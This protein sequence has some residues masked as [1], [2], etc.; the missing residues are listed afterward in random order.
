METYLLQLLL[1]QLFN[2]Q[3]IYIAKKWS[4]I[5]LILINSICPKDTKIY[6][7][8]NK[9]DIIFI[10][11]IIIIFFIFLNNISKGRCYPEIAKF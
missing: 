4:Y 3:Q 5:L 10:K 8:I 6:Y 7:H 1:L 11:F 2:I 9:F